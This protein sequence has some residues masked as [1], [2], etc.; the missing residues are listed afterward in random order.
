MTSQIVKLK[1]GALYEFRSWDP[2][3]WQETLKLTL[4]LGYR[5]VRDLNWRAHMFY[6]ITVG[7]NTEISNFRLRRAVQKNHIIIA[8]RGRN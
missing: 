4:Y 1:V 8:E 6:D 2:V 3:R 7:T 5:K